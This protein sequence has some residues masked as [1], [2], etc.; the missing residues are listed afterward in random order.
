MA[1]VT[2]YSRKAHLDAVKDAVS[3]AIQNCLVDA[4]GL[5]EDKRFHRFIGLGDDDMRHPEDR[6]EK[7]MIIEIS[8]FEGR[9][10]EAKKKL[11]RLLFE[12]VTKAAGASSN[13]LEITLFETPKHNWG[14]RGVPGDELPINYK[15]EV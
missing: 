2:V 5:P 14:S 7:Y 1:Q 8:G 9:S 15:V 10:I 3:D 6:T 12:R 11:I 4:Y 13:A